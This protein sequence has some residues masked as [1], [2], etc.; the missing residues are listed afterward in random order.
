MD[1]N[2]FAVDWNRLTEM[3]AAV[4]VLSFIVERALAPVV[5]HRAFLSR[6]AS[7]G[8]KEFLGLAVGISLCLYWQFDA[9]STVILTETVTVPGMLLTGAVIAG[10]SKASVK[11]FHDVLDIRSSAHRATY[12]ADTEAAKQKEIKTLKDKLESLGVK[13]E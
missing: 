2:L 5:E 13:V 9:V 12:P 7:K 3:L 11:L 8:V 4:V 10:G 1:P 6:F